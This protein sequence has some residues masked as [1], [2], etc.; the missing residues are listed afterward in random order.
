MSDPSGISGDRADALVI[1]GATGDLAARKI[2]PALHRLAARQRL[3]LLMVGVGRTSWTDVDLAAAVAKARPADVKETAVPGP[4]RRLGMISGEYA[5]PGTYRRLAAELA[6]TRSAAFYLATPP[7]VFGDIMRGLRDSGLARSGR[8]VV[9]KPFGRD[10]ATASALEAELRAAFPDERIF[11]V[12]HYL[13][14]EAVEGLLALRFGNELLGHAW[15]SRHIAAVELTL[16]EEI[17]VGQRPGFYDGTGA[18]RDILQNHALQIVTLLAMEAP[19]NATPGA[20]HD[21]QSALL[22]QVQPLRARDVLLG[23]YA[24]YL[25][26]PGIAPSSAT[27]TFAAAEL[28]IETPRWAGVPFRVRAGK[29][30]AETVSEAVVEFRRPAG[31]VAEPNL[32]RLRLGRGDGIAISLQAKAPGSS[33]HT[34]PVTLSTDYDKEFGSRQ[35]AYERLLDDVLEGNQRR[36]P[37]WDAIAQQWRIVSGIL[38]LPGRPFPYQ[39]GTW[40]PA[41]STG[42]GAY[43]WHP[44][45]GQPPASA[46]PADGARDTRETAA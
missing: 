24:G 31:A 23:Q 19:A 26:H 33:T 43:R 2:F 5:D 12:D 3:D 35:E 4:G 40:G 18:V 15:D 6:G 22:R 29:R 21:A 20:F 38:D 14:K 11:R 28:S 25:D 45:G 7:A 32:I 39:P 8:V 13:H 37:R 27:E 44:V 1:F 42:L 41:T 16:A 30:M 36:F 46:D 34:R 9:E 10:L 17:G